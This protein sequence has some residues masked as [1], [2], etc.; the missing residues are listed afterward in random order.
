[1]LVAT[2]FLQR[3]HTLTTFNLNVYGEDIE[4]PASSTHQVPL[5]LCIKLPLGYCALIM[6]TPDN[7]K[8]NIC[9][10]VGLID[11]DYNYGL[12]AVVS[13]TSKDE[14]LRLQ[15]GD[16]VAL[17]L[18]FRYVTDIA[19]IQREDNFSFDEK[20]KIQVTRR[21]QRGTEGSAAFDLDLNEDVEILLNSTAVLSFDCHLKLPLNHN[22]ILMN[23]SSNRE[24]NINVSMEVFDSDHEYELGTIVKNTSST[25]SLCL[26]KK[27]R[28]A[29]LLV[30]RQSIEYTLSVV[31]EEEDDD[32]TK[33]IERKR[34]RFIPRDNDLK[35]EKDVEI[36]PWSTKKISFQY[37]INLSENQCGIIVP[38][39]NE[40]PNLEIRL[41]FVE[42]GKKLSTIVENKT[43]EK[44]YLKKG[45]YIAHLIVIE[46]PYIGNIEIVD[47]IPLSTTRTGGFGSTGV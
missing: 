28:I 43:N 27:Q 7:Y 12:T 1:M 42:S 47:R 38:I 14:S 6:D 16:V 21:L 33:E 5:Q 3:T 34:Q 36:L 30:F 35:M 45:D 23:R 25:K 44:I 18:I 37:M 9:V 31:E 2:R 4:I 19:V 20:D 24:K 22:A 8:R 39:I 41:S 29:Q 17:L 32:D 15:V 13:N 11:N 10:H 26:T 46:E 40:F